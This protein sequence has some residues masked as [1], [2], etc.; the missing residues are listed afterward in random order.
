MSQLHYY[1]NLNY[2]KRL[3]KL[4]GFWKTWDNYAMSIMYLSL[5]HNI[6]NKGYEDN[7]FL[8]FFIEL[9]LQNIHPNPM[10]RLSVIET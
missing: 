1:N 4:L 8:V 6:Y 7:K 3:N 9:L 2:S 10:K 5:I